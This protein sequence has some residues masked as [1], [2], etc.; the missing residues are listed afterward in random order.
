MGVTPEDPA[1]NP[2][3]PYSDDPH[4]DDSY[5]HDPHS[6]DSYTDDSYTDDSHSDGSHT[7]EPHT[8]DSYTDGP[9]SDDS[10]TDGPHSDDSYTH[11]PHTYDP[12]FDDPHLDDS[13]SDS[14]YTPDA[15]QPPWWLLAFAPFGWLL[16]GALVLNAR[17]WQVALI[18]AL[19][20]APIGM[21]IPA[22][23]RWIR[24]H[25]RLAGFYVAPLTFA[26]TVLL[27]SL[28]LWL[29]VATTIITTLL[30]LVTTTIHAFSQAD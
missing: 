15:W 19:L 7:D 5:T 6:D 26:A 21:P 22:V 11:D 17:G 2:A 18:A 30:A 14:S 23:L 20:L 3:D 13:H 16:V 25:P 29:C 1:H 28:P 10:Y 27:T 24:N 9:H 4:P 8:G 12:H